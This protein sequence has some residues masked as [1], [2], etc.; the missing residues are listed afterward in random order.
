MIPDQYQQQLSPENMISSA[1]S[2]SDFPARYA[3]VKYEDIPQNIR[4]QF[5]KLR[6]TRKGLYLFGDCGTGKT[7]IVYALMK[8]IIETQQ[9]RARLYDST[10]LLDVIRSCYGKN[11]EYRDDLLRQLLD[12]RGVL[13]IDDLG[14]EKMTEWVGETFYKIVN[15]KYKEMIPMIFTSNLS[16]DELAERMGDRI[17][18]RIAEMCEVVKL[19]GNDRR[20]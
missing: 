6:E 9:Y 3:D 20:L 16:L 8:H 14:V 18:S 15:D 11:Y 4:G 1:S 12:F 13:I 19:E 7:H 10:E 2:L 5:E 17:P